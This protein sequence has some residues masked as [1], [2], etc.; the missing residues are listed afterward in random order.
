MGEGGVIKLDTLNQLF[1]HLKFPAYKLHSCGSVNSVPVS[2]PSI[3]MVL[4]RISGMGLLFRDI[5]NLQKV[6][7]N[8]DVHNIRLVMT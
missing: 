2:H 3:F 6:G 7:M 1:A 4:L 5:L 8:F